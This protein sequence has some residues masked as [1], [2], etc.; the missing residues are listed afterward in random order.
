[1]V[2]LT[3]K[4][5]ADSLDVSKKKESPDSGCSVA[6]NIKTTM[7]TGLFGLIL[8][9]PPFGKIR[10]WSITYSVELSI[11]NNGIF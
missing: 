9:T 10:T 5:N 8:V 3:L 7:S 4:I 6:I 11:G 1:M 2:I